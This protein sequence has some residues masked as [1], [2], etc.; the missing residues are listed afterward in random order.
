MHALL[1]LT[2]ELEALDGRSK[3]LVAKILDRVPPLRS[4]VRLPAEQSLF[5]GTEGRAN[6]YLLRD[7]HLS[8][9]KGGRLLFTYDEGDLLG[10]Q[11]FF[12]DSEGT[13]SSDFT[14]VLDEYCAEDILHR[15]R[16]DSDLSRLWNSYLVCQL[17]MLNEMLSGM[18]NDSTSDRPEVRSYEKGDTIV[19]EG[20]SSAE[21]FTM[22]EGKAEI[23]VRGEPVGTLGDDDIFGALTTLANR[24]RAATVVASAPC[25][26][27]VLS[28]DQ[29][30]DL[31]QK[32]PLTLVQMLDELI[33]AALF[34]NSAL[35]GTIRSLV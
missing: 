30:I 7:G 35:P 31:T 33:N 22:V 18:V 20:D 13:L 4:G 25:L 29:F 24:P 34:L 3:E 16:E 5:D 8:Y 27:V 14:V 23:L 26:V 19:R 17:T 6:L 10:L 15:V 21:V 9:A 32:R 12:C 2:A 1:E 11:N 28:R